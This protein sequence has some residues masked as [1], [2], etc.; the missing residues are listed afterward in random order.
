M[1]AVLRAKFRLPGI[2]GAARPRSGW[3][4]FV[5]RGRRAVPGPI[6][7]VWL[8]LV[9]LVAAAVIG[10]A[11]TGV[12]NSVLD[13]ADDL[14]AGE[15]SLCSRAGGGNCVLDGDTIRYGGVKIGLR[16]ADAP[17]TKGAR[18]VAEAELGRRATV[19]MLELMNAGP[20]RIVHTGGQSRDGR[21]RNL[22]V[23][24]R[25][26]ESLGAILVAEGLARPWAEARRGWCG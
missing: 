26:G 15:F 20:F 24:A 4:R 7:P 22:R 8:P 19:R 3:R 21:G 25:R 16:D 5:R 6:A 14:G 1:T 2:D 23:V 17:E 11:A 9:A 12:G 13:G 18:C 10:H